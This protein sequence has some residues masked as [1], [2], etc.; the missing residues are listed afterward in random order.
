MGKKA[1]RRETVTEG[2]VKLVSC[3][4]LTVSDA[5]Q[6]SSLLMET[7]LDP[8]LRLLWGRKQTFD[9]ANPHG[10]EM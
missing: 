5:K 7:G 6:Y 4:R 1:W 2:R 3:F 10:K 9:S 8:G